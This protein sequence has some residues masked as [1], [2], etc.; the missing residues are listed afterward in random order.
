MKKILIVLTLCT[1][2][3]FSC[4]KPKFNNPADPDAPFPAPTNL[5]ITANSITSCTLNWTDN[6]EGEQGFKID[7]KKDDENWVISYQT[8][9]EN[10]ESF[11]ET[12]LEPSSTYQYRVYGYCGDEVSSNAES[13]IEM[14]FPA[15]TNLTITANSIT[16]CT[17]N[18]TDNSVGEQG[19]KIDRK[20]DSESWVIGYQTVGEN[21]ESFSET[22]LQPNSTYQYRVYGYCGDEVSSNVESQ[23]EMTFPAP[24]NLEINQ[25]FFTFCELTWDYSGFGDENGFKIKRKLQNGYW[26]EVATLG[27]NDRNYEDTDLTTGETYS[28][29]VYAYNSVLEGNETTA[30]IEMQTIFENFVFVEG[31]TFLMGDHYNE[32]YSNELPTHNVT[33]S[34]FFICQ[35]EVTQAEYH[36]VMG[37]NP[38]HGYGVGYDYPVYYVTWY[39]AVEYCNALSEQEGLTP[40]YNTSTYE[41]DFSANGYRL[42]TEAEWEYAARGGQESTGDWHYSGIDTIGNVAVYSSGGTSEV[43]SKAPNDL[44]IYDMSGNVW[45]WCN[46]RYDS[47]YYSNS[48]S[49]NPTG[50]DNGWGRVGRGGSWR[51][52]ALDCRVAN[53]GR[54]YP[55]CSDSNL[56]F[57]LSR[58]LN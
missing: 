39:D 31:G 2:A 5:T 11:S 22:N 29:M 26:N 50:P 47:S 14:N 49:D 58:S 52:D 53:R 30:T 38:A 25:T 55:N 42:P 43:E 21:K 37:E 20:K 56:G 8:V 44:G 33:L 1:L 12:N 7:R 17:L 24:T 13:Q 45:E 23:I 19:F 18:W 48:P 57:R 32:G 28:Y 35:H 51:N 36:A 16:S 3:I 54:G 41:C 9:G 46:D 34:S 10:E 4:D 27:I 6:S 15:P 40:C